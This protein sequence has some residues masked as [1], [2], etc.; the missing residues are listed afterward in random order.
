MDTVKSQLEML[1]EDSQGNVNFISWRFK[2]NLALKNKDLYDMITG[3]KPRPAG[4][5]STDTV[6]AWL[7]KD[8]EAQTLIGLNVNS[9]IANKIANCKTAKDMIDKLVSLYGTKTDV[10]LETSRIK[11]FTYEYDENKSAV[12]NCMEILDLA[13]EVST[14]NDPVRESWIMTRIMSVLPPK[15]AHF[16]TSWDNVTGA[17]KNVETL[18]ERLRLEDERLKETTT[19]AEGSTN[20]A[21]MARR[22][23]QGQSSNS[24]QEK[25]QFACYKCGKKG[26]VLKECRGKPCDEYIAYCKKK[27]SCNI[28]KKKGHFAKD[29]ESREE[30]N[31]STNGKQNRQVFL[32]T[33]LSTVDNDISKDKATSWYQDCG[34]SQHMTSHREWFVQLVELDEPIPIV[35]GD[36]T[37]LDGV[38]VGN[39]EME[40]F[41]G[42]KWYPVVLEDVIYVPNLNF[43]LFSVSQMLDKGHVQKANGNESTFYS[44]DGREIVAIAKRKGNLYKMMLRR[45]EETSLMAVSIKVWHERLA[46]QNVKYVRDILKR[47]GIKYIDDWN[48]YVCTGCSYGKLH[49]SSHPNNPKTAQQP[50]DLVH[51]DTGE[52]NIPSLGGAKYWLMFKDDFTHYRTCYFMKTKSEAPEKIECYLRL[53]ENQLGRRVK[54]LRSDNGTE[55]KNA[56][57]K[58]M[59]DKLGIFHTFTNVHTPEQNGRIEREMRTIVEAAR[60]AIHMNELD[61]KL[62]AE[63]MNHAIFTINQTGTS[64]VPGKSPAELWFGRKMKIEKLRPFGCECYVLTQKQKRGKMDRKSE[65]GILV[66]YDID[67]PC[68]RVYLKEKREIISSDNVIFDEEKMRLRQGTELET[69]APEGTPEKQEE[70]SN[71]TDDEDENWGTGESAEEP[72]DNEKE[73]PAPEEESGRRVLRDRR[74]LQPPPR[75]RDCVLDSCRGGKSAKVAMIG[76]TEDIPVSEALRDEKWRR[77]MQ[78]EYDSLMEMKTW[79]LVDCPEGAKPITCRWVL[80]EKADGR[81]KARLVARGFEQKEGVDYTETFSPVA[82]HASIR[83]LLSHA[84]SEKMKLVSFDVKTAFLYGNLE[85]D[86]YM[87]QPEGFDDGTRKVCKLNKSLY[88][89]K[90]AP[91][92]WNERVTTHFEKKI[93]LINTDD[94]PC[95]YYNKDKSIMLS[96]FV[97]DGLVVGKDEEE[98]YKL[99]D[100]ISKEFEITFSKKVQNKLTYLGMEIKIE[101][102]GIFV[103]QPRYTEKILRKMKLEQCNPASTPTEP[104]MINHK[105]D[106]KNDEA[107]PANN[108]YREAIGSLLYLATITR[109]DISFAVN[110]LSRFC[111]KPMKSHQ[112]MVKRVFQYLR[113][114]TTAG[115]HFGGDKTLVAYTDSDFGGDSETGQSTSGVLVMRGGPVIWYSQKQRLVATSTAEAEYRAAVSVIDDVCWIKRIALEL[116]ILEAEQPITLYVDNMSAIHMLQNAHEGKTSR[117]KKHI[118]IPRKYIQQHIGNTVALQHV[119]SSKQ[120]ADI[121]TKPLNRRIFETLRCK[122]IKEEC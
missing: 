65:K 53:V 3:A 6:A 118:E 27:Y 2:L 84:A 112:S 28:C 52:M 4:A 93:G 107:L 82:R 111:N 11:F 22:R 24:K 101:Q 21:L 26:H 73:T 120:I 48:D 91:R 121:L 68:Y 25:S 32:T 63:A 79:K 12:E 30:A 38:A 58:Q 36:S 17:A 16:R 77:A 39:I 15:L 18:M 50:L 67:S 92:M 37:R 105:T 14:E 115:I 87:H 42:Q 100:E 54:S 13:D 23:K 104:G 31:K 117:G 109:P 8:V 69:L 97:D 95:I 94:D 113:G 33:A 20:N 103:S 119:E 7:K 72:S 59:M 89:L 122:L 70:S 9:K 99:L 57:T 49:R 86:I 102:D 47:K 110:Y 74:T 61:E 56:K 88:G 29:C 114:T 108:N 81:F 64:N 71:E 98:I 1:S 83:L 5:A 62:W 10:T 85:Q 43:N 35:I 106:F 55:L 76:E 96:L 40:A 34:A 66:G 75:L 41:D 116:G 60:T 90:Q 78:E 80:R 51:V 44:L 19:N 46:H 45:E